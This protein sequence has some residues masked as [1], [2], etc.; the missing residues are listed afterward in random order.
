LADLL[1]AKG[2][3]NS[4][5][6]ITG[7]TPPQDRK[8]V[9]Q[10]PIILATS[11]IDVGFNF[12]RNPDPS[13]Q[14]LDWLIFSARD[15]FSFWQ[16]IGRV[17]RV[18]GKT[19]TD[20][21]SEAIAYLPAAAWEQGI[22]DLDCLG[23][24][25]A[26]TQALEN[27]SCL[28]RPFLEIY[29]RSEAFLEIAR[30]LLELEEMLEKLPE[31]RVIPELYETLQSILGGK[32]DW[33][34]YRYRMKALKGAEN[35]AKTP[36]KSLKKDWKYIEGGQ[37]FVK[38]FIKTNYP[39][40]WNE[41]TSGKATVEEY[42]QLFQEDAEAAEELKKF[43][44]I[45]CTSYAPL[46]QFRDTLFEN[47][48][49]FDPK[50]LLLDESEETVLDPIH[51]LRYYEFADTGGF[52]EVLSRA[53]NVYELSFHLRYFGRSE[54][55]KNKELNKLTAFPNCRVERKL[56]GAIAPTPLLKELEQQL[57]PGVIIPTAVN[58]GVIIQLRKQGLMSYPI[59][60]SCNDFQ[61]DYTFFPSLSGLLAIA[62]SGIK[63]KLL[64]EEDF[65][66]L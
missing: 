9:A 4:F 37:A 32:R 48:R 25:A 5:G 29:W 38:T 17:G 27:L 54:Q 24:R 35:I 58:Q 13:R 23:G 22:N 61:K 3:Q 45:W 10:K 42:E 8:L 56:G 51:L 33:G 46:F 30:P 53:E 36:L 57:L 50:G 47:L 6:R 34:H 63:L 49:I 60:V 28:E 12:E 15:R 16:R 31:S 62:M 1:K 44:E 14:N 21:P 40:E 65:H 7:S 39:E 20:V 2:L 59:S 43:A 26:L 66:I 55:F 11:T 64:D 19:Q 41:L 52:I 18:L